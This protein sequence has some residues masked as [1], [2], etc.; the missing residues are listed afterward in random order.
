MT[1]PDNPAVDKT[2]ELFCGGIEYA[3]KWHEEEAKRQEA[4]GW[5]ERA[6]DHLYHAEDLRAHS[7]RILKGVAKP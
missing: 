6:K 3:A 2:V 7:A 5:T 1:T 4:R